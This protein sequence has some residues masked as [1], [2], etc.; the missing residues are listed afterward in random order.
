MLGPAGRPRQLR[1]RLRA[2]CRTNQIALRH[3]GCARRRRN[4]N[5]G[6]RV[7]VTLA[8][9][10]EPAFILVIGRLYL[11]EKLIKLPQ[12]LEASGLQGRAATLRACNIRIN[13]TSVRPSPFKRHAR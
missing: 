6:S 5:A 12:Y 8:S 13:T 1:A 10:C 2:N 9:Y 7:R 4:T 3:V 11:L